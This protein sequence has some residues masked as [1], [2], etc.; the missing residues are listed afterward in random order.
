M[1]GCWAKGHGT[2]GP[3]SREHYISDGIFD[4]ESITASGLPWC[5][6]APVTIGLASAVAKILCDAHN[7]ALS[8]FDA[9]AAKLSRFLTTAINA[10]LEEMQ[11]TLSGMLLEKWAI[12]TL[13]NLGYIGALDPLNHTRLTPPEAL[14]ACLFDGAAVPD[15]MGLYFVTGTVNN[16]DYRTGLSWN[17]LFNP[18]EGGGVVGMAFT[19]NGIHFV[20]TLVPI[21]AEALI[22]RLTQVGVVDYSK[23]KVFYRPSNIMFGSKTAAKREVTLEW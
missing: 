22:S 5:K 15:G 19:L 3:M 18:R 21:R 17:S 6:D 2:C 14:V 7:S 8:P 9:E 11:L 10:P 13:L 1:T 20:V 23:A 4:G 16:Q 12:K